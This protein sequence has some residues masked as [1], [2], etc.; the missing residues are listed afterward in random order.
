MKTDEIPKMELKE[1]LDKGLL[2]ELNRLFL[3]PLGLAIAFNIDKETGDITFG[4]IWDYRNDPEGL[5]ICKKDLAKES[6][7]RKHILAKNFIKK[8]HKKRLKN[9]GF[10]IQEI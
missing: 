10:I 6:T 9:L 1:F 4:S 2:L 8:Q 7:K 3:H 5:L